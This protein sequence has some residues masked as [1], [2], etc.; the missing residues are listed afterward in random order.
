[1]GSQ[2]HWHDLATQQ[3]SLVE[4]SWSCEFSLCHSWFYRNITE[5]KF[6]LHLL[7]LWFNKNSV[8]PVGESCL[9]IFW[10]RYDPKNQCR[11]M[12]LFCWNISISYIESLGTKT[13]L[14][15]FLNL[16]LAYQAPYSKQGRFSVNKCW[17]NV[18]FG[19]SISLLWRMRYLKKF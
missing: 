4:T 2:Q 17:Q 13:L 3:Q 11:N 19:S 18:C 15:K 1:M 14:H 9:E 5:Q 16:L 7:Y 10:I 8:D 6:L 12:D